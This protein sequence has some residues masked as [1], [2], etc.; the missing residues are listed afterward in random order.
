MLPRCMVEDV[1]IRVNE[2]IYQA[3]FLMLE[4]ERVANIAN[5]ILVI[6]GGPFLA[7]PN[8]WINCRN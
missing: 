4:T 5:H 7:I 6:I 3:D 8:E 1:L 2:F